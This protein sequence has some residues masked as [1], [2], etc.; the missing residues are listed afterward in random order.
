MSKH[1]IFEG[2]ALPEGFYYRKQYRTMQRIREALK[3]RPKTFNQLLS[4]LKIPKASL[5]VALRE[6]IRWGSVAGYIHWQTLG[7]TG[8]KLTPFFQ[9]TGQEPILIGGGR[10]EKSSTLAVESPDGNIRTIYQRVKAPSPDYL[11]KRYPWVDPNKDR[12]YIFRKKAVKKK[13]SRILTP[14]EYERIKTLGR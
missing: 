7:F 1:P 3:E 11:D 2:I 14:E 9:L 12:G 4:E 8:H 13:D 6:L 5:Y 10:S